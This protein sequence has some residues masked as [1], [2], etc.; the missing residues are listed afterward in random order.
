MIKK[1]FN[2]KLLTEYFYEHAT[3][4]VYLNANIL[5]QKNSEK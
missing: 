2:M 1:G 4:I 3:T 5:K